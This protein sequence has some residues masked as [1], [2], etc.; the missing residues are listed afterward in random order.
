MASE[1]EFYVVYDDPVDYPGKFVVRRW[2]DQGADSHV[3]CDDLESARQ[4]IPAGRWRIDRMPDHD[5]TIRELW[6]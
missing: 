2:A 3:V 1:I 6:V 5:P 4:A